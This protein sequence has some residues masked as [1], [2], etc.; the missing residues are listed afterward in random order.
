MNN[1]KGKNSFEMSREHQANERTFLAWIRTSIALM[2]FGFVII[3]FSLFLNE[4]AFWMER[5]S[6]PTDQNSPLIGMIL[7]GAG[8]IMAVMSYLQYKKTSRQLDSK[9]F[10]SSVVFSLVLTIFLVITGIAV[11]VWYLIPVLK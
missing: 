7:V 8:I 11:F 9:T 3:K 1:T 6:A 5:E 2:G 4:V 10:S